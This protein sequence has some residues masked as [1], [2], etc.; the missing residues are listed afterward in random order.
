M[1]YPAKLTPDTILQVASVLLRAGGAEAVGM[2]ALAG[3]LGVQPSSLYR[4]FADRAAVLA[5]LEDQ[6]SLDLNAALT[7]AAAGLPPADALRALAHA[8]LDFARSDPHAYGLLL[9]PRA[10]YTAQP[11]AA[12]DL[13]KS[14][15]AVVGAV[16]GQTDDTAAT[17]A[18]W[19]YLHGFATLELSGQFGR[20]GP[21]GGF[22]RGLEALIVGLSFPAQAGDTLPHSSPLL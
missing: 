1:P 14:V 11:G 15:L 6:T 10:P 5:A 7:R 13:W 22:E 8:Y 3:A 20:S 9:M 18:F 12:Q 19:A 21:R 4:H 17:V 16:T 2:R